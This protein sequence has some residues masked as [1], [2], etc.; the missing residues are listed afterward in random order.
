M[1]DPE[2]TRGEPGGLGPATPEPTRRDPAAPTVEFAAPHPRLVRL[3]EIGLG[4]VGAVVALAG[5]TLTAVLSLFLVPLRVDLGFALIRFPAAVLLA[6]IGNALLLWFARQATGTR[7]GVL[8]PAIGW[9]VIMLPALGSTSAG[10]RLM[11]P[12]DWMAVL[13][14]FG[15]TIVLT[16]GAVLTL[17]APRAVAKQR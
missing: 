9:F 10:S 14:L 13:T 15:G 8:V 5:G 16:I 1:N 2:P 3:G 7:W 11:M 6:V 4:L 12:N 17:A